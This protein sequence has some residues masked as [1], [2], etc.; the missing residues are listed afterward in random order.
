VYGGTGLG[1]AISAQ[2][3]QLMGGHIWVD[4]EPGKGATFHFTAKLAVSKSTVVRPALRTLIELDGLPV[5]VVDD[6]PTNL[7]I[8]RETLAHWHMTPTANESGSEALGSLQTAKQ[9]GKP[10]QLIIVDR[11]MP[12][13]DGFEVVEKIRRDSS[14][15]RASI[16]MLSSASKEGDY[17]RCRELGVAAYLSKPVQQSALLNAIV[18]A[19]D[20][21]GIKQSPQKEENE[22][23]PFIRQATAR[24]AGRRQSRQSEAGG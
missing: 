11:N 18:T 2:L 6:N 21:S 10:F 20:Q 22:A 1:L 7:H 17:Q 23:L 14:L 9:A 15:T 13:M 3:V 5:L 16:M 12:G 8:L 4:S 24:L 19:M